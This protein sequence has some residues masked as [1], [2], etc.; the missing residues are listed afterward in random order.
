MGDATQDSPAPPGIVGIIPA[1]LGSTRFPGKVL[2]DATGKPLIQHVYESASRSRRLARLLVAT[3]D[4]RVADACARFGA[5]A[6][7]TDASHPNGTSRLAQAARDLRLADEDVVVNVQGDEPEI[8][9]ATIDAAVDR[10]L[11]GDCDVATVASPFSAHESPEDPSLVKVV[12]DVRGRALYF[13]R[14][15][16]PHAR[17][18]G[19][20]VAPLRHVGLYAYRQSFLQRYVRLEPTPLENAEMLEQLRVLEH[21]HAIGVARRNVSSQ[22]IDTPEQYQ[23][24]VR[25]YQAK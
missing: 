3:D 16:I 12:L 22:G 5:R 20:P 4:P 2:A 17:S 6:V 10:L 13:S 25:R 11:E 23:A 19:T 21:G 7:M 8:D 24:F 1:R 18:A 14:A 9:P 15:P